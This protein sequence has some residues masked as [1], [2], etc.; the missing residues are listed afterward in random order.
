MAHWRPP[1][2]GAFRRRLR[3]GEA[4]LARCRAASPHACGAPFAIVP[5]TSTPASRTPA[6]PHAHQ[7]MSTSGDVP[8]A[9]TAGHGRPRLLTLA[10]AALGVV[11]GDIGTSPLYAMRESLHGAHGVPPTAD[12]VL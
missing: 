9:P 4:P 2:A 1:N 12:N 6:S 3:S 11:Y 5:R 10:L 7:A 8:T